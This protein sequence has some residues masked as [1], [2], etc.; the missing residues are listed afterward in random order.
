M[1]H[2]STEQGHAHLIEDQ[3]TWM[4]PIARNTEEHLSMPTLQNSSN[5]AEELDFGTSKK[6]QTL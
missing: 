4:K 2:Q 1:W 6:D 3:Q 5:N